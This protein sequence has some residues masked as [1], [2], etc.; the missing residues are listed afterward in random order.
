MTTIIT[1]LYEEIEAARAAVAALR[2]AG[3]PGENVDLIVREDP[4]RSG[5]SVVE[6]I[7]AARVDPSSAAIYAGHVEG[8]R[9]LVVV[10][11]PVTPFGA[12]RNA[13][14]IVDQHGPMPVGGVD[15]NRY[16]REE[17]KRELFLSVLSDHP[18]WFSS[19]MN[20]VNN[21]NRGTVSEAFGLPPLSPRRP[22]TSA[23]SGGGFM[24][25]LFWPMP[26]LSRKPRGSSVIRGGGFMSRYF[27]PMPLVS[28][29]SK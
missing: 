5:L 6:R 22:R 20:P 28:R 4:F 16:V 14:Y 12:A 15:A 11:A 10:R 29:R 13:M 18:R 26:L 21:R 24:S 1:R 25:K 3:H 27:W 19:D 23:M 9:P 17:P 8:G 7:A 2:A